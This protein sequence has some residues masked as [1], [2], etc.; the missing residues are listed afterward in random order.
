MSDGININKFVDSIMNTYDRKKDGVI[1]MKGNND[2]LKPEEN[3]EMVH[4]EKIWQGGIDYKVNQ[5]DMSSLFK[6][7]DKDGDQKVSRQDLINYIS[8]KYDKDHNGELS[9]GSALAYIPLIGKYFDGEGEIGKM[10]KD[11]PHI[12]TSK[13]IK[14]PNGGHKPDDK[15]PQG[16][17][18]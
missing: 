6:A 12:E 18:G 7:A 13:R 9:T 3:S 15:L 17:F 2:P 10:E 16:H 11:H 5:S 14:D 1:D 8:S 4:T